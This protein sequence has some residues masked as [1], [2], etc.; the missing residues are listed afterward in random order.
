VQ[1][2]TNLKHVEPESDSNFE[3]EVVNKAICFE[4]EY[5]SVHA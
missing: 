5:P 2:L 3:K 1:A 4:H